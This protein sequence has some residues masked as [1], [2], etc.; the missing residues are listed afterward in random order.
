[1]LHSASNCITSRPSPVAMASKQGSG[2]SPREPA[3]VKHCSP[4]AE[5]MPLAKEFVPRHETS[6]TYLCFESCGTH[7]NTKSHKTASRAHFDPGLL[8]H[9][10]HSNNEPDKHVGTR[11]RQERHGIDS[12]IAPRQ[13]SSHANCY[14][15]HILRC[16]E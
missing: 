3:L 5:V 11:L 7:V 1:M 9:V 10:Q 14:G 15:L 12:K 4:T 13:W 2:T 6:N 16:I 8:R